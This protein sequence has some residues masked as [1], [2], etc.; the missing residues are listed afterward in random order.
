M[1]VDPSLSEAER[2]RIR[3][4]A[5]RTAAYAGLMALYRRWTAEIEIE[6]RVDRIT[7]RVLGGIFAVSAAA[8]MGYLLF[9]LWRL[10]FVFAEPSILVARMSMWYLAALCLCIVPLHIGLCYALN[11]VSLARRLET[12]LPRTLGLSL[13]FFFLGLLV[14]PF[15]LWAIAS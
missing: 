3:V 2:E 1:N 8:T 12:V 5:Q 9:L 6:D 13:L 7:T 15:I 14:F 11:S 4:H 10:L